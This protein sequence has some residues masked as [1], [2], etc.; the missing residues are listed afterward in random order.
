MPPRKFVIVASV[1][2]VMATAFS[3]ADGIVLSGYLGHVSTIT[4]T[5]C[6]SDQKTSGSMKEKKQG[7]LRR[8]VLFHQNNTPANMSSQALVA[9]QNAGLELLYQPSYLPDL[10]RSDYYLIPILMEFMKGSKFA[11]DDIRMANG[12][13]ET[14]DQR[15]NPSF[16]KML[17]QVHFS[18]WRLC[19]K[20]KNMMYV[21][22]C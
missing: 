19:W 1:R 18:C 16:G 2:K 3:G 22:C 13:L 4:G 15:W 14:H 9:I 20:V 6:W 8:G 7:K 21:A 17:D 11:D 12:W 5:Y 10:V